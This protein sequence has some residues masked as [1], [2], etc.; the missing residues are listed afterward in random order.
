M[1]KKTHE[2]HYAVRIEHDDGDWVATVPALPGCMC[3]ADSRDAAY[4]EIRV[5]IRGV[6]DLMKKDGMPVPEPDPALDDVRRLLP[7]VNVS[8]LAKVAGINRNTLS[9]RLRRGTPMPSADV[10][11]VRRALAELG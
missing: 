2:D 3:V 6:L 1:K 9:A 4:K 11:K 8:K 5:L 7:I 10:R